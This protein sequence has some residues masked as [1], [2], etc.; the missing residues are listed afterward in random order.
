MLNDT[1]ITSGRV[2]SVIA[3]DGRTEADLLALVSEALEIARFERLDD[4]VPA[5]VSGRRNGHSL[6]VGNAAYF[7]ALGLSIQPLCDWPDRVRKHGQQVLFVA[8][9]GRTAGF[10]G[11][12]L[13]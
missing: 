11:I 4:A 5:G 13:N 10:L 12:D 9:D 1:H 3:L 2:A 7:A 8:V 6:T